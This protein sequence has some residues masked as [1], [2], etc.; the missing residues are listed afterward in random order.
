M[1]VKAAL[2]RLS[3]AVR[4]V[5][6]PRVIAYCAH[7]EGLVLEAYKDSV[8][9]W[10]WALGVTNASGHQV[11]PRYLDNPQ[12]V[13]RCLEVSIWL[14]AERYLPPV[15]RAF[16]GCPMDEAKWAAALSFHW[17]TGAI[18]RATWAQDYAAG[19]RMNARRNIMNWSSRGLLTK[20]RATERALFF[21]GVWPDLT[22]PVFPV[23]K[24]GYTPDFAR[25]KQIDLL[26]ILEAA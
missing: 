7:E 9:V 4:P 3:A 1:S 16:A 18:G 8:N 22:V 26:S 20:R 11:H 14:M 13:E 19:D 5:L 25:A 6:S 17:N 21:D 24:P 2:A 12:S 15:M 10:T 23:R